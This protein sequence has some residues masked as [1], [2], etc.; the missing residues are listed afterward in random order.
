[1]AHSLFE[2]LTIRGDRGTLVHGYLTA[3]AITGWTVYHHRPDRRHDARW[4]LHA[5]FG[6]IDKGL[7][8][9]RPLLFSGKREGL[10]GFWCFPLLDLQIGEKQMQARLGPPE[11]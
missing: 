4:T 2:S 7:I 1:V 8:A 6:F 9:K 10:K 11:R 5:T 3:A